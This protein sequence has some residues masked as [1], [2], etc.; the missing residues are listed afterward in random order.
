MP[1]VDTDVLVIGSGPAGSSAALALATYGIKTTVITKYGRL[2][3]TPRAHITNQRTMEAL[4]DLGVEEEVIAQAVHQELMGNLVY[5]TS[6]AGE[7]LGR[8]HAW[9]TRPDRLADYTAASP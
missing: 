5:C 4:R 7:E 1:P 8:L 6:I 2:A 9:G 3:D